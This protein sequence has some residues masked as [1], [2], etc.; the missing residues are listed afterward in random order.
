MT[1]CSGVTGC[2]C[3][4]ESASLTITG[5]GGPGDPWTIE[6]A[7]PKKLTEA[8]RLALT[9]GSL[10][11]GLQVWTT[12]VKRMWVYDGSNWLVIGGAMPGCAVKRTAQTITTGVV[13][14]A[15][16]GAVGTRSEVVDTDGYFIDGI[17]A[18]V[19]PTGY[20]GDYIV[21][22]GGTWAANATGLRRIWAAISSNTTTSAEESAVGITGAASNAVVMYQTFSKRLRLEAGANVAMSVNQG[23][24]GD[25][26]F[27]PWMTLSM[28]THIPT[29]T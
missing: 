18:A 9:G 2:G 19:V 16:F 3:S 29:L 5:S 4:I 26:T 21:S 10:F 6:G 15:A 8:Q 11:V 27:T 20:G 13:T 23:S 7:S 25:L 17:D 12:D 1:L 28:V 14:T 22:G 24:G